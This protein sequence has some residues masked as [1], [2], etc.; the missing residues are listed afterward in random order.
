MQHPYVRRDLG[1]QPMFG[2]G[3][4][5]SGRIKH[6]VQLGLGEARVNQMEA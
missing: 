3:S 5:A 1:M 4:D 6:E 2:S